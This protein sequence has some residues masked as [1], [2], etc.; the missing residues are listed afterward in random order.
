VGASEYANPGGLAGLLRS[1]RERPRR[2]RAADERDELASCD[3][4]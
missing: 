4:A 1:R 2:S 3:N